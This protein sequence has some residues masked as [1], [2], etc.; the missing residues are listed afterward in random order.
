MNRVLLSYVP[1]M[2]RDHLMTRGGAMAVIAAVFVLPLVV[3]LAQVTDVTPEALHGQGV[4]LTLGLT[5]FL[6]LV[7]TYGLV[8][9]DFRL[10][11]YRSLFSKPI[12]VPL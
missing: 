9:H 4:A 1:H 8:G 12:S 6:T 3:T 7:A 11:S 5:P 2:L 10:G